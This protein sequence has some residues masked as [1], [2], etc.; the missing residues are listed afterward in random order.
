MKNKEL[1]FNSLRIEFLRLLGELQAVG[2]KISHVEMSNE[3]MK[4]LVL[5]VEKNTIFSIETSPIRTLD[6]NFVIFGI[7]VKIN[8]G[9]KFGELTFEPSGIKKK[10]K[11]K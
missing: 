3:T 6:G 1:D 5:D 7:S 4:A 8:N 9:L 11:S 10:V 2:N